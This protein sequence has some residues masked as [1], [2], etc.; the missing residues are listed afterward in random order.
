MI[1]DQIV[2][3]F[4]W[5]PWSSIIAGAV[6]ALA[7][8][9]ILA[10]LGVALGF[11]VVA[12]KADDPSSG[13]GIA[14][15][16]WGGFSILVCTAGG[17]FVA[18]LLAGQR[19]I[20]IGFLTWAVTMLAAMAF[21][22]LAV[23]IAV[24]MIGSAVKSVGS[25]AAGA[26]AALGKTAAE[27][28]SRIYDELKENIHLEVEAEKVSDTVLG[29]LR[30]T[31]VEQLQPEY[32]QK[33]MREAKEGFRSLLHQ[34]ALN[35]QATEEA[36]SEFLGKAKSRLDS[37]TGNIDRNAAA[38]ALM[39]TRDI[40]RG[41]AEK[42]V[43]NA[44]S[45]YDRVLEKARETLADA[46]DQVDEAKAQLAQLIA[47]AREKADSLASAAAKA[48]LGSALALIL[49]AGISMGAGYCGAANAT[50]WIAAVGQV[51]SAVVIK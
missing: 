22:G 20:E 46:K 48:A 14:L 16:A 17:G 29:V 43:D 45:A 40:P 44:I 32:L 27:A 33:Q 10:V 3:A 30:D 37:L 38:T 42:M 6:T 39:N 8:S 51:Q 49:A 21:S 24:K 15:G 35:P 47:Q 34:I 13:L 12:P 4:G 25:G 41:E 23:G 50:A 26:A 19:G 18:G 11:T 36:I 9:V 5:A 31:E 1:T 28:A 2:F 7:L